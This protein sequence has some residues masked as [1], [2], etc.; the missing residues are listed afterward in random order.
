MT[1]PHVQRVKG[2]AAER[3]AAGPVSWDKAI[4]DAATA[5]NNCPPL[6]M[7]PCVRHLSTGEVLPYTRSFAIRA[8]IY[9]NCDEMGNTDPSKW[10][11]KSPSVPHPSTQIN[12]P[13]VPGEYFVPIRPVEPLLTYT[14]LDEL[15]TGG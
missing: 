15:M 10:R 6:E 1:H 8:D 3:S 11:G 2:Q 5:K 4:A 14:S 12:K 7:S 9:A 13:Q